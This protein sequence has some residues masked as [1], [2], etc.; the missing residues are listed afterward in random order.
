MLKAA[1]GGV[2]RLSQKWVVADPGK[3]MT[4][5]LFPPITY[6]QVSKFGS[7]PSSCDDAAREALTMDLSCLFFFF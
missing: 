6:K 1:I 2:D 3:G 5:V 4:S 7:F